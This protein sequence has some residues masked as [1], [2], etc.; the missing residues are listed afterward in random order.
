MQGIFQVGLAMDFQQRSI[1]KMGRHMATQ[2]SYAGEYDVV[3]I[4]A[5]IIGSMIA[6][7]LSRFELRVALFDKEPFPGFGVTKAGMSQ[8]HTSDFCPPGTLKGRLCVDAAQRFK[9]L[10][11]QLD[12]DCRE[13]DELWLALDSSQIVNLQA[14]KE[15]AEGHGA[16][17]FEIIGPERVRELEP[18]VTSKAVAALYFRGL[19]VIYPPELCFAL[20]ENAAQNGLQLHLNTTVSNILAAE[21]GRY[22]VQTSNGRFKTRYIVNAAGLFADEIARM[23][24]DHHIRLALRKGTMAILDKSVSHLVRHMI[25]GTFS[26]RHSQNIA[27]TAH[28]NLILGIHYTKTEDKCDTSVGPEGIREIMKLGKEL[29]PAL[30]EKD[31]ITSFAGIIAANTM[32]KDNDFY[33]APSEHAPGVIHAIAGA[34]GLTGA[35]AIAELVVEILS[36]AGLVM[37]EKKAFQ[38]KRSG[39][40]RFATADL[41]EQQEIMATNRKYGHIVCRCERVSEA[42]IV[43]AIDRGANTLDAVKH[44]TRAGMGRCQ[45][46]FCGPRVLGLLSEDLGVPATQVTKKGAGSFVIAGSRKWRGGFE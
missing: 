36:H 46:G 28:G 35:P 21:Q 23:V 37:E 24:Q 7:E 3:V 19:A 4:G 11:Q 41:R 8:I 17:G 13:T 22:I 25:Y 5:G 29:V 6:R 40:P 26:E 31:I 42:E 12:V 32:T 15:R 10:A 18:H 30:S 44:L 39:W 38:A 45:G 34:P 1:D 33:I 20:T 14:A 27:P 2:T 9:K 16:T 43:E